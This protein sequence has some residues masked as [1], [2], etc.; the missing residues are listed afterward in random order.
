MEVTCENILAFFQPFW[1]IFGLL[2]CR[3]CFDSLT[4]KCLY[5]SV[6]FQNTGF[7]SKIVCIQGY[8]SG[9]A[10]FSLPSFPAT[11]RPVML[12]PVLQLPVAATK[13]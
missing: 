11:Q 13:V 5:V 12:S 2:K 9:I 8:I 6:G 1:Y 7:F 4:E 3:R 10:Q